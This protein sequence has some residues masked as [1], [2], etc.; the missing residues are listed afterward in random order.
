MW[1]CAYDRGCWSAVVYISEHVEGLPEALDHDDDKHS[2][3]SSDE[4]DVGPF[5]RAV[6]GPMAPDFLETMTIL[7]E[8]NSVAGLG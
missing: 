2:S 5:Q 8:F 6:A 4:D 7:N 1:A 3:R